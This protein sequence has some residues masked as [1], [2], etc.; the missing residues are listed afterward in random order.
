MT[1]TT[2]FSFQLGNS[3][4]IL[5][6]AGIT[7]PTFDIDTIQGLDS[8]PIRTS[9]RDRDGTDGGYVDA[10]YEQARPIQIAGTLYDDASN[11]ETTLDRLKQEWAPSRVPVPLYFQA[12]KIGQRMVWVKPGGCHYD[13]DQLRRLGMCKISFTAIAGD[14]RIYATTQTVK[15]IYVSNTIQTGFGFNLAFNFGFGGVTAGISPP[16]IVN[17]GNRPTPVLF[18]MYGP[19][20]NPHIV[21]TTTGDE[22]AFNLIVASSLDY[23]EVDTDARTVRFFSAT[24][25]VGNFRDT[26]RR[27]SWFQLQ[28]GTNVIN[29]NVE[30]NS[31]TAT[32]MDI[33]FRSAW[34]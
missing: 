4:F 31:T 2:D 18:R 20:F 3:G 5:N 30:G 23:L 12:P 29:F 33:I 17:S 24:F 13:I 9:V 28:P 10:E 32:H 19:Y 11:T 6:S 16:L 22:M 34:R 1:L 27:P 14:P 21:N 8:A 26:L 7:Y 15:T 25:G